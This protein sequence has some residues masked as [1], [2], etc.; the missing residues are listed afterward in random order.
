MS[1]KA[2]GKYPIKAKVYLHEKGKSRARTTHIDIESPEIARIIGKEATYCAGKSG[3]CFI[4]LKKEMIKKA[5]NIIKKRK[6]ERKKTR[7]K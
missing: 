3:G 6:K 2:P 4:G 5:E 1:G 7:K